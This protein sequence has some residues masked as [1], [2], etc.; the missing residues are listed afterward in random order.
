MEFANYIGP[1][2]YLAIKSLRFT[3][4]SLIDSYTDI[5]IFEEI[6]IVNVAYL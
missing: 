5:F 3:N 4:R 6:E 2:N 1:A